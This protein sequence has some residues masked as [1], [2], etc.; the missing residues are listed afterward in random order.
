MAVPE[1]SHG[2]S[3]VVC[4]NFDKTTGETPWLA[5]VFTCLQNVRLQ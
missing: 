2:V 4:H 3:P 1:A 5:F